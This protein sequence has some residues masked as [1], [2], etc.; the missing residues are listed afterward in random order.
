MIEQGQ[1]IDSIRNPKVAHKN[2]EPFVGKWNTVGNI[3]S[4]NGSS[5]GQMKGTDIYEWLPGGFFLLHKVDVQMDTE[6]KQSIEIIGYDE[7]TDTYPMHFYDNEGN[8]GT[9][10]ASLD[11]GTWTFLSD[12]LRFTGCF[13]EDGKI[14]T[15][16]WE[17]RDDTSDWIAWME[18]RLT[19]GD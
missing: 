11:N 5:P 10:H 6:R 3:K 15:G 2:L 1:I 7:S 8:S 4:I 16:V 17:Q 12:T 13:S 18:V 19:R 9:L 14:L